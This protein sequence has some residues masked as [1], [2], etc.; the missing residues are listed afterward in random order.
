MEENKNL[1]LICYKNYEIKDMVKFE[2]ECKYYYCVKCVRALQKKSE[3]KN[4]YTCSIC[5][6]ESIGLKLNF[7]IECI[8][9]DYYSVLNKF[10][11][12]KKAYG[13][14]RK[15]KYFLKVKIT[16]NLEVDYLLIH[17]MINEMDLNWCNAIKE[18]LENEKS[19]I[20]VNNEIFQA[21]NFRI[22]I[23]NK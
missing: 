21:I 12:D 18:Y 9:K 17:Y 5:K 11:K 1:C 10:Y 6:K 23:I 19:N 7:I 13:E 14:K 15:S 4:I 20:N 8:Q 3:F 22:M 16:N 2:C